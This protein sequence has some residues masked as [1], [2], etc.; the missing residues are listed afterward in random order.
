[1]PLELHVN[2]ATGVAEVVPPATTVVLNVPPSVVANDALPAAT[3]MLEVE[4]AVFCV[5]TNLP[6]DVVNVV[7][8]KGVLTAVLKMFAS[9]VA[10]T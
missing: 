10:V 8:V 4:P 3:L 5:H 9:S 2:V 6:L 7:P 1:M